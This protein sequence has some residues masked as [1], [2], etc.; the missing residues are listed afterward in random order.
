VEVEQH[1]R[2]GFGVTALAAVSGLVCSAAES[3]MIGHAPHDTEC[4]GGA[5]RVAVCGAR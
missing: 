2:R 1:G 4:P 5:G 3:G